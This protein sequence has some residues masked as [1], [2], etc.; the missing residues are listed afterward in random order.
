MASRLVRAI[1]WVA[2]PLGPIAQWPAPL[3]TVL[4]TMLRSRNPMLL[5]WGPQLTHFFNTAFI[6]SLDT[7][8]FPGA[9]G[10]PGEQA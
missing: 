1:D 8:Q 7:R 9:M 4:G 6:P 2:T 10:Q 3:R 5:Y